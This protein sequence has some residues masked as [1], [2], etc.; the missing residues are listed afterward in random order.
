MITLTI[1]LVVALVFLVP[2]LLI[3]SLGGWAI[4]IV[5]GDVILAILIIVG[6]IKKLFFDKK[7]KK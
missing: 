7:D 4:L 5:F 3:G 6:I 1:L 2:T